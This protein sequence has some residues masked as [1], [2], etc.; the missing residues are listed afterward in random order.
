L[1]R[2][3]SAIKKLQRSMRVLYLHVHISPSAW[4]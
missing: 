2:A 4:R 1:N 3:G